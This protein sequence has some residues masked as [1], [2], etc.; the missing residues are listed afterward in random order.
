MFILV[1]GERTWDETNK[2]AWD[3]V[4]EH[5][6]ASVQNIGVDRETDRI[7]TIGLSPFSL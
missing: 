7:G 1:L 3:S 5:E 6:E 4:K 2:H